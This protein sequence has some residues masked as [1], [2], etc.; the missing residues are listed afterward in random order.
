[1]KLSSKKAMKLHVILWKVC[2]CWNWSD[3]PVW[4]PLYALTI[5]ALFYVIF[6]LGMFAQ[7]PFSTTMF[8]RIEITC[9]VF[10]CLSAIKLWLV[11]RKR[12]LIIEMFKLMDH[13]DEQI[14][15]DEFHVI[16]M[17]AVRR[18]KLIIINGCV[19]N[20]G[21]SFVLYVTRTFGNEE[22]LLTWV[23]Y[24][25]FEYRNDEI[26]FQ[27]VLLYQ[28]VGSIIVSLV[29]ATLDTIGGSYYAVLGAHLEVLALRM[30]RLGTN[31]DNNELITAADGNAVVRNA[32]WTRTFIENRKMEKLKKHQNCVELSRCVQLHLSCIR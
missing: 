9:I 23:S 24:I 6:P 18:S 12:P 21:A 4:Y 30:S 11:M 13:L 16:I 31:R 17:K 3:R 19:I 22:K 1:M 7:F 32:N 29:H 5:Y 2:A 25:P 15:T 10:T 28:F 8:E 27:A 20:C 26:I 14:Q